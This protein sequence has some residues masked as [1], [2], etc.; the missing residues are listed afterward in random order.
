MTINEYQQ[1]AA[2]TAPEKARVWSNVGLGLAGEAGEVADMIKKFLHQGHPLDEHKLIE[3]LGDIAWYV[4]LGATVAGVT[5]EEILKRNVDK[6]LGRYPD[7]F[8]PDRSLHREAE[9]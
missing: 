9:A 6:L 7:G 8:D 2:R 1:A 3:E 4:A 5:L